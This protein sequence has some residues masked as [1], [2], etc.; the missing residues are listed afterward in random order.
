MLFGDRIKELRGRMSQG[1]FAKK[2]DV[3]TVT[4]SAIETGKQNPSWDLALKICEEY[5]CSM[6]WLYGRTN[7][8]SLQHESDDKKNDEELEKTN[9]IIK[10]YKRFIKLIIHV[11]FC[12]AYHKKYNDI[13]IYDHLTYQE[14]DILYKEGLW[15]E[16]FIFLALEQNMVDDK[17]L[18]KIHENFLEFMKNEVAVN[19]N[20]EYLNQLTYI[21]I[22]N[23]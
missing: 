1:E 21:R 16:I 12:N 10:S 7:V 6:D 5:K 8:R 20:E 23:S 17:N 11:H 4:I 2:F 19:N 18:I 22:Y 9:F 14:L 15:R 3:V 13:K